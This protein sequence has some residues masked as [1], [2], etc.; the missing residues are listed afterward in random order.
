MLACLFRSG[1]IAVLLSMLPMALQSQTIYRCGNTYSQTPCPGASLIA[2]GDSRSPEQKAQTDAAAAQAA[3]QAERMERE[4][5]ERERLAQ[6]RMAR[7][8]VP[9]ARATSAKSDSKETTTGPG[10]VAKKLQEPA[11]FTASSG[12][13]DKKKPSMPPGN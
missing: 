11:Y 5:M 13:D 3:R 1:A 7:A 8:A 10:R 9:G 2:A 12:R 4:R 6:E